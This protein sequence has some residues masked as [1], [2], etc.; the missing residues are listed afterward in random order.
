LTK[1]LRQTLKNGVCTLLD[2]VLD[3]VLDVML[4]VMRLKCRRLRYRRIGKSKYE[5]SWSE[6]WSCAK[7]RALYGPT[8]TGGLVGGYPLHGHNNF[9]S[10]VF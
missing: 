8:D 10:S 3:V 4:D 2:V 6:R 9:Q 7:G 1:P 5:K